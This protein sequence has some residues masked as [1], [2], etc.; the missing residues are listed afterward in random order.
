MERA[1]VAVI[2][3]SA[4]TARAL[5]IWIGRPEFVGWFNHSYYYCVQVEGLLETGQLP[6]ADLPFLFHLYGA[7]ASLFQ[8]FG[9][10][11]QPS[12]VNSVRLIMSLIDAGDSRERSRD[13]LPPWTLGCYLTL[14]SP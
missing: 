2:V 5:T 4:F 9:L 7:T 3:G 6:Y 11:L 10:E 12:I 8:L 1:I 13:Y 14:R